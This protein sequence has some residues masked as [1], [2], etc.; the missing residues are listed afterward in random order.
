MSASTMVLSRRVMRDLA[1]SSPDQGDD[2]EH[3]D[4]DDRQA[5]ERPLKATPAAVRG[6]LPAERRREPGSTC[7]QEDRRPDRDRDE[8]LG[9]E[10]KIQGT[11]CIGR[12][13]PPVASV[14]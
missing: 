3:D 9:D 11:E 12:A 1:G 6:G 13:D 14:H 5:E 4:Q 8:H 7:L 10:Q 2:D